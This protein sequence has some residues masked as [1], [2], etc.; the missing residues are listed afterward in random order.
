[1]AYPTPGTGTSIAFGTMATNATFTAFVRDV[2]GPSYSRP[3]ID[4]SS[5]GSPTAVGVGES[6]YKQIYREF[7]PGVLDVGEVGVDL[8][9]S[10][11][12]ALPV[13]EPNETITITFPPPN[14]GGTGGSFACDGFCSGYEM[15]SPWE[16][17]MTARATL[18]LSGIPT[19]VAGTTAA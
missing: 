19:H 8:V 16:G 11:D 5:N 7:K 15:T 13:N 10:P 1:M 2:T 3:A 14:P 18:K 4:I 9:F 6:A 17:E 12:H